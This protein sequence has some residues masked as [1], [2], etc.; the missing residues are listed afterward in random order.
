MN[1]NLQEQ[2][3]IIINNTSFLGYEECKKK[4]VNDL[5]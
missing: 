4:K 1:N 3:F 5:N 2:S